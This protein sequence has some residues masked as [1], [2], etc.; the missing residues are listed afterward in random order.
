MMQVKDFYPDDPWPEEY[1]NQLVYEVKAMRNN[2]SG[3]DNEDSLW[4]FK[5]GHIRINYID[6]P[7]YAAFV[8]QEMELE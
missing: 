3:L 4:L 6:F 5:A 1:G 8:I 2:I 7:M